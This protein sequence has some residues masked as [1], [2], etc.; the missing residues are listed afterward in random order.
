[1]SEEKKVK[2]LIQRVIEYAKTAIDSDLIMP[3]ED[4]DPFREGG[5]VF[6]HQPSFRKWLSVTYKFYC[7]QP[8]AMEALTQMGAQPRFLNF[9]NKNGRNV[10]GISVD[11]KDRE[12]MEMINAQG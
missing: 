1:M 9:K 10:Y 6:I 2:Y 4:K 7:S 12:F 8:M 11:Q 5:L 3:W